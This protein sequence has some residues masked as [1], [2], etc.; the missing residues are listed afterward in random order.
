MTTHTTFETS[1]LL[2]EN[3]FPQPEFATGQIW[4]NEHGVDTFIGPKKSPTMF[5][6]LSLL[7]G[8]KTAFIPVKEGA[9]FAPTASDILAAIEHDF[10]DYEDEY[11]AIY[12]VRKYKKTWHLDQTQDGD[13]NTLGSNENPA[14]AC[15]EAWLFLHK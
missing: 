4:Y 2:A 12:S 11:E 9:F 8:R 1:R 14:E 7:T 10:T 5:Y 6:V 13:T 15:A 3:G